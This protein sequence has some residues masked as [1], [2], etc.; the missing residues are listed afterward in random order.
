[1]ETALVFPPLADYAATFP[2]LVLAVA[3]LLC[4]VVDTFYNDAKGVAI[5]AG[6]SLLVTLLYEASRL[7]L[8]ASKA[9]FGM[10]YVGGAT[11]LVNMTILF[12]GFLT[13]LIA[14]PYLKRL[15]RNYGEV[16]ALLLVAVVGMMALGSAANLLT[17]FA[18]LETMSVCLYILTA[19]VREKDGAIESALKYFLLGA[20]STGFLLYGIALIYGATGTMDLSDFADRLAST[21]AGVMFWGGTALLLVGFFFKVSAVP[22]HMW[23]PDVYQGAPTPISGFMATASKTSA[24]AAMVL[25]LGRALPSAQWQTTVAI[26]A[27]LSMV[28]GNFVALA[29]SNVKRMLAY[30]SIAHAGYVL[31]GIASATPEGYAGAL[32]YLLVYTVMNVGAFGVLAYLEHDNRQGDTQTVDSLAGTGQ[33]YPLLGVVMAVCLF[34]LL[35]FPPLAGFFGKV[36]VFGPAVKSGLAW[37]AVAG[38][39]T[40]AVS[41]AYYLR[42]LYVMWMKPSPDDAVAPQFEGV[43]PLAAVAL[44]GCAAFL[45]LLTFTPWVMDA[46]VAF[47]RDVPTAIVSLP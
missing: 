13:V 31:T 46:A 37:L 43:P 32:Y 19:L 44:A 41:A 3:A 15:G 30:S 5:L 39:L 4:I 21:N 22:F 7:S 9:L 28:I 14:Q 36:Y 16:Y 12:S 2:M 25:V 26:V 42:V 35:G 27:L 11:S 29:Q 24:F 17:L 33:R 34:S 45:L 8:P 6:A 10:V 38:V 47:F 23:T 18:G 20:F 40:S 1:M